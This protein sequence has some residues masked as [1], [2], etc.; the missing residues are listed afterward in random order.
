MNVARNRRRLLQ[1]R[2]YAH[3]GLIPGQRPPIWSHVTTRLDSDSA[4][5]VVA[6]LA[7]RKYDTVRNGANIE[8]KRMDDGLYCS[9]MEPCGG[10]AS[11]FYAQQLYFASSHRD[12]ATVARIR[13]HRRIDPRGMRHVAD[14]GYD[15]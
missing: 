7:T 3:R 13:L 4:L 14:L 6:R 9:V 5:R 11:C 12:D 15:D 1:A 8:A 2:R 10:C